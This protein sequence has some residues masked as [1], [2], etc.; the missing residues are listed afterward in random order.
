MRDSITHNGGFHAKKW[1]QW[2]YMSIVFALARVEQHE[3]LI[4]SVT[5]VPFLSLESQDVRHLPHYP[6][7]WLQ[8]PGPLTFRQFSILPWPSTLSKLGKFSA[9]T[10]LLTG[11]MAAIAPILS[12]ISSKNR[13]GCLTNSG[14]AIPN[15]SS[16]S[17]LLL[18]CCMTSLPTQS[19]ATA[20]VS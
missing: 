3:H 19:L 14:R 4:T 11:S 17:N 12:L 15:Y 5:T 9:T 1:T 13:P 8:R 2:Q 6:C 16:G 18:M 20:V 10:H 7:P